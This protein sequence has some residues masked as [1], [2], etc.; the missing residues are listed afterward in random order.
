VTP[1]NLALRAELGRQLIATG[2]ESESIKAYADLVEQI[3]RP[4]VEET[5]L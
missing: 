1:E 3:D 4:D 2:N 5:V